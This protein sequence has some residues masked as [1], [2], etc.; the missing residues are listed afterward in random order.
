MDRAARD[1]AE[2]IAA[3]DPAL[4]FVNA[5]NEWAEGAHLEPDR[6]HGYA[7]LEALRQGLRL[8]AACR[9]TAPASDAPV[10]VIIHAFYPELLEE[11]LP[12]LR[13]AG[14]ARHL[15]VTCTS[16]AL[17][18]V[19]AQVAEHGVTDAS[20]V[21]V[22]NHG[23]D[24]APFLRVATGLGPSRHPL[25]LKLH[26]KRS[27]HRKDGDRWREQLYA[28]LL[29]PKR[30]EAARAALCASTGFGLLGPE[31]SVVTMKCYHGSNIERVRELAQRMG[32]ASLDER[33][34]SFIAGTMF[35][36]R[37]D[38]ILPLLRLE[39]RED[40][41]EPECGQ[42]DGTLAHAI[43]RAFSY[44]ALAAGFRLGEVKQED[45]KIICD[46]PGVSATA[47]GFADVTT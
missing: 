38:A 37:T 1:T 12:R 40:D 14:L 45:G 30:A 4:L 19:R 9:S 25:L 5:W 20:I 11:I 28:N 36:A 24:V 7:H 39:I 23:R 2:R 43:E 17:A 32:V 29:D 8:A 41:F 22:R 10:A 42:I 21:P 18:A 27:R 35:Y 16:E 31:G 6:R 44:S 3:S 34:D 47:F 26:T 13:A 33:Y 46:E 15:F